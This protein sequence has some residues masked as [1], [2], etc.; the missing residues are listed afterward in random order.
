MRAWMEAGHLSQSLQVSS[1]PAGHYNRICE[2]YPGLS[3]AFTI[4]PLD[5][6][7]LAD[8]FLSAEIDGNG[9][10]RGGGSDNERTVV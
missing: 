9:S 2:L 10:A 4:D 5:D 6:L 8:S 1:N 3:D 7:Q